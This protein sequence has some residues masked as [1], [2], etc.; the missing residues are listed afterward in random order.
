MSAYAIGVFDFVR[1]EG[2][3]PPLVKPHVAI[4]NKIGQAGISAQNTG[5]HGDVFEAVLWSVFDTQL[6]AAYVEDAYRF[7]IGTNPVFIKYN[8]ID[9]AFTFQHRYLILACDTISI[10]RH[11][12][13]WGPGYNF[14]GGWLVKTRWQMVPITF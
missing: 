4:F 6:N 2:P 14:P 12:L 5:A 8:D 13:L 11:P 7:L 3:P 1:W 10:K 9:Y